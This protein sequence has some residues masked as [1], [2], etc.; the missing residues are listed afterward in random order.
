MAAE[1]NVEGA[2]ALAAH[3]DCVPIAD[4]PPKTGVLGFPKAGVLE[5]PIGD[6]EPNELCPNAGFVAEAGALESPADGAEPK[7]D[8]PNAG[9][10][11]DAGAVGVAMGDAEPKVD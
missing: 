10:A 1:P 7:L 3:G 9:F 4:A 11:A 6:G 5:D 8:W 2:A